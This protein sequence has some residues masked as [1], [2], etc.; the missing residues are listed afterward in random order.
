MGEIIGI[1]SDKLKERGGFKERIVLE[2]LLISLICYLARIL[3][4]SLLQNI[5]FFVGLNS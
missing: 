1:K 2:K 5:R 4:S 3:S